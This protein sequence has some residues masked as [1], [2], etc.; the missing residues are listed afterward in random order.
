L[1]KSPTQI[2][3]FAGTGAGAGFSAA[4]LGQIASGL[5]RQIG[6]SLGE[7][8]R[9]SAASMWRQERRCA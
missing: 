6:Q 8:Y 4:Q 5:I 3:G 9:A 7:A 2:S 1:Y